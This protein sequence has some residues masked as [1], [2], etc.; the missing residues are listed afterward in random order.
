M[1]LTG[2]P[3]LSVD[4]TVRSTDPFGATICE[5]GLILASPANGPTSPVAL[6][7]APAPVMV[8]P[9]ELG[10]AVLPSVQSIDAVPLASVRLVGPATVPPP[11]A[12]FQCTVSLGTAAP[13]AV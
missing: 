3:F 10:P 1:L 12:T 11:S 5:S 2:L 4:R 9:S 8:A 6:I 7:S 13:A